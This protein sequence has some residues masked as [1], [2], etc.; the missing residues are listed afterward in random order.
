VLHAA[1]AQVVDAITDRDAAGYF[2][3]AGYAVVNRERP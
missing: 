1:L 2:R 3:H